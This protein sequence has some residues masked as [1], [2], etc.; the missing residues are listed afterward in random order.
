MA[1]QYGYSLGMLNCYID[2][3]NLKD[4]VYE[5]H[6]TYWAKTPT[7]KPEQATGD[8]IQ[9]AINGFINFSEPNP[10]NYIPFDDLTDEIV[11]G[12]I[13][14]KLDIPQIK[15][16]L[17]KQIEDIKHPTTEIKYISN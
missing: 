4:L 9:V 10:D 6:Y 13:E 11:W 5:A 1:T 12:W 15:E 2:K 16:S 7:T 17:D 3:N 14:P 8:Q